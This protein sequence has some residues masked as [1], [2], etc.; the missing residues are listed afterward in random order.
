[1]EENAAGRKEIRIYR[2]QYAG[3]PKRFVRK[4]DM[5]LAYLVGKQIPGLRKIFLFGSCARGEA[6]STSDIDLLIVTEKKL[7]DRVLAADIRW[8]LDEAVDGVSTDV[9]YMNEA[10]SEEQTVFR[11]VLE[12]DKKLILE[13]ME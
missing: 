6:R 2:E 5:D 13:V 10:A 12:R 1:M 9:V 3:L 4:I 8:T 11:T 7:Q